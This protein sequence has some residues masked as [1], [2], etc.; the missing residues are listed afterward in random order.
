MILIF[1]MKIVFLAMS[2]RQLE[3]CSRE[4]AAEVEASVAEVEAQ[5]EELQEGQLEEPPPEPDPELLLD[6]DQLDQDLEST[7]LH[8]QE[9]IELIQES[10]HPEYS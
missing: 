6:L 5:S 10:E 4:V 2:N 8:Q 9:V 3:E 1:M 7:E